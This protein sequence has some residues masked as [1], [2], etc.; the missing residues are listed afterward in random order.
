MVSTLQFVIGTLKHL[1][2]PLSDMETRRACLRKILYICKKNAM[3]KIDIDKSLLVDFCEDHSVSTKDFA[4]KMGVSVGLIS[5]KLRE[6][7]LIKKQSNYLS[8]EKKDEIIKLYK[9]GLSIRDIHKKGIASASAIGKIITPYSRDKSKSQL[10]KDTG[11]VNHYY[12]ENLNKE[13]AYILGLLFTDG[14]IRKDGYSVSLY[15]NDRYLCELL[16]EKTDSKHSIQIRKSRKNKDGSISKQGY[17]ISLSSKKLVLSLEKWGLYANKTFSM[18]FPNI[19]RELLPHFIRGLI[20][21]DGSIGHYKDFAI[22]FICASKT[23]IESF[24][25]IVKNETGFSGSMYTNKSGIITLKYSTNQAKKICEY[26]YN[27]SEGIRLERKYEK[28]KNYV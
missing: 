14:S 6:H 22:S 1:V 16:K 15:S 28:F 13:S 10:I 21:G 25:E 5:K 3:K 26:I 19:S 20:D 7:K 4:L 18:S 24:R 23:F 8:K 9:S 17:V 2:F 12:F 27:D 11:K